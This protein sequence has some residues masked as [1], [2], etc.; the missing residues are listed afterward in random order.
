MPK[1]AWDRATPAV[2]STFVAMAE[3]PLT[4]ADAGFSDDP[5]LALLFTCKSVAPDQP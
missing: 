4:V 1:A 3:P 5:S 2:P